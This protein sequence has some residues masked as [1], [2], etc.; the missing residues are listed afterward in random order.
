VDSSCLAA[1]LAIRNVMSV[2]SRIGMGTSNLIMVSAKVRVF[3][4]TVSALI[5]ALL[6][7]TLGRL[8]LLV[9]HPV[10]MVVFI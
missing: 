9:T 4:N 7:A 8:V 5:A 2:S 6:L 10:S 3:G 1:T